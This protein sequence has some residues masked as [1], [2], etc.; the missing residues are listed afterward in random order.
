M[1][2]NFAG[3]NEIQTALFTQ[4]WAAYPDHSAKKDAQSAFADLDPDQALVTKIT[5]S[6]QERIRYESIA[7]KKGEKPARWPYP[8]T[9]LRNARWEDEIG[10]FVEIRSK[11]NAGEV[12]K[13]DCGR[14]SMFGCAT[15]LNHCQACYADYLQENGKAQTISKRDQYA[16]ACKN[17]LGK[18]QD[19]TL[20]EYAARLKTIIGSPARLAKSV[21]GRDQSRVAATGDVAGRNE[22]DAGATQYLDAHADHA[23]RVKA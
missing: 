2:K 16:T 1:K 23:D 17:G 13:C 5:L 21:V 22:T 3:L 14:P 7:T 20:A 11:P 9:Y 6:I 4:F 15:P 10:S 19:E 12:K 8:A 18:Q